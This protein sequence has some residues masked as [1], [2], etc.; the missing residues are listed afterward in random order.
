MA[1]LRLS[2]VLSHR[3]PARVNTVPVIEITCWETDMGFLVSSHPLDFCLGIRDGQ[4]TTQN[5]NFSRSA[6]NLRLAS[7]LLSAELLTD[8]GNWQ[9]ATVAL[10][11]KCIRDA[12]TWTHQLVIGDSSK[13]ASEKSVSPMYT[14]LGDA[15]QNLRLESGSLLKA[16]CLVPTAL[17]RKYVWIQSEVCLDSLLGNRNGS[18]STTGHNFSATARN[19]RLINSTLHAELRTISQ[20]WKTDR[21]D[22]R[23]VV[24]QHGKGLQAVDERRALR[25]SVP[26]YFA[27]PPPI[28]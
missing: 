8:E 11:A 20:Q 10:R 25:V 26:S 3:S 17:E 12:H 23:L 1:T 9:T 28:E 5:G 16:D 4:F 24:C 18:F 21:V 13:L 27:A 2:Y 15:C 22:L 14:E 6:R 7:G 19:V